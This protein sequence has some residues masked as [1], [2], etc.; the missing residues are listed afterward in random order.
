MTPL[1]IAAVLAG[2]IALATALGLLWKAQNGRARAQ[3]GSESAADLVADLGSHATLLQFS[4]EVCSPCAAMSRVL[5]TVVTGRDDVRHVELDL[6]RRPELATRFGILQTP[7]TLVLDA[8][9]RIRSRIGGAARPEVVLAQIAR[10][11][12]AT[13]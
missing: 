6:T 9:G 4:T 11:S 1:A 3:S 13:H 5:D 2:L 7:T 10:L 12:A 8:N